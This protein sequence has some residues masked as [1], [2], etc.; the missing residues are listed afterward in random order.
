MNG[1]QSPNP[2]GNDP[3]EA[4]IYELGFRSNDCS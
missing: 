4:L 2:M 3:V 1:E